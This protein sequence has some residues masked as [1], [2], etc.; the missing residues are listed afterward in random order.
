MGKQHTD[1]KVQVMVT[2]IAIA[3]M[4]SLVSAVAIEQGL[5]RR[6]SASNMKPGSIHQGGCNFNRFTKLT[7][8]RCHYLSRM[9][10]IKRDMI[11]I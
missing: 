11:V 2:L 6:T 3:A 1:R 5:D 10:E 8:S 9:I 4:M 7:L